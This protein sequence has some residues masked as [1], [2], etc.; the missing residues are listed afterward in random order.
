M[1]SMNLRELAM[2][3]MESINSMESMNL[4]MN[5]IKAAINTY[6]ASVCNI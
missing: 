5:M 1:K 2:E 6:P 3:S 4:N